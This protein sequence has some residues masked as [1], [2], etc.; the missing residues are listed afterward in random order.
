MK[1]KSPTFHFLTPNALPRNRLPE[2]IPSV[3]NYMKGHL[4]KR[5]KCPYFGYI[6]PIKSILFWCG[7]LFF[8]SSNVLS[9]LQLV[10]EFFHHILLT[11]MSIEGGF[12]TNFL[13]LAI[14]WNALSYMERDTM[15]LVNKIRRDEMRCI[16]RFVAADG[17]LTLA[18]SDRISK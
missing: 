15:T 2:T 3:N 9:V 14:D 4:I 18:G 1:R 7:R 17:A 6:K 13:E 12:Q 5:L 16:W 11:L 8:F 10:L